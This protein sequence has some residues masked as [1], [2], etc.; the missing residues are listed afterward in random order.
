MLYPVDGEAEA[1]EQVDQ[2]SCGCISPC[3]GSQAGWGFEPHSLV[4]GILDHGRRIGTK[5]SVSLPSQTIL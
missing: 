1:L 4:K 5:L 3:S 2:R